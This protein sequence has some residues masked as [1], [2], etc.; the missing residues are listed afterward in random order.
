MIQPGSSRE[1]GYEPRARDAACL[2]DWLVSGD[3][4]GERDG[5]TV[6]QKSVRSMRT[7]LRLLIRG[8]RRVR[9]AHRTREQRR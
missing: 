5:A 3:A 1:R 9:R 2:R 4:L 6:T 8:D 7:M